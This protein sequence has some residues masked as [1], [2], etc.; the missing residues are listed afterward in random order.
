MTIQGVS[1][2]NIVSRLGAARAVKAGLM[3]NMTG[4]N[5]EKYMTDGVFD[6]AKWKAAMDAYNTPTIRQAIAA[7][8]ADGT[9]V[10]NSV[11][12][13]PHVHGTGDG[14]TWGPAGTMTKERVDQMCSYAK[15]IFP[16]LPVGVAQRHGA[17]EPTKSY[18]V[19]EFIISSYGNRFG[20][21]TA[22]RDEGLAMARRD[23]HA[24]IFAF[25]I[26]NGGVQDREGTWDCIGTGGKGTHEPNC[27]MTPAQVREAGM[28]LGP[29]GCALSM[30][31]YDAAFMANPEN[32]R[33]FKDVA[34]RLATLPAKACR[35]Q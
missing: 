33:A 23:G 3:L 22:F 35:R 15:A 27:R 26:L 11:M 8:V 13:E 30:W 21:V 16:T 34:A 14:N 6:Y 17:F 29:A 7:A 24:I 31:R 32:Q 25:N 1:P 2:S 9:I 12:D 19:C 10:G 5:H 28:V 4:G 20:S 18:R